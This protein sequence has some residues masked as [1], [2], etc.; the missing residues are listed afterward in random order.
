MIVA[1]YALVFKN[2]ENKQVI[3]S[4]ESDNW[5]CI[6]SEFS[7]AAKMLVHVTDR[8]KHLLDGEPEK[9][10]NL[11]LGYRI[12]RKDVSENN[13]EKWSRIL[14]TLEVKRISEINFEDGTSIVKE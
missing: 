7:D 12:V 8:L 13:Q 5:C 6:F 2:K 10:G 11:L 14:K 4:K 9:E 3:L 1:I